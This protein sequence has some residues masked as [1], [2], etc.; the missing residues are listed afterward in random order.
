MNKLRTAVGFCKSKKWLMTRLPSKWTATYEYNSRM[1]AFTVS[2]CLGT[3]SEGLA[4]RTTTGQYSLR[5]IA[6]FR[7]YHSRTRRQ[8]VDGSTRAWVGFS[9]CGPALSPTPLSRNVDRGWGV[10]KSCHSL[11][12][13]HYTTSCRDDARRRN[14]SITCCKG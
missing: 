8:I 3:R 9:D 5:T 13:P 1:T 11:L 6:S 10:S 14:S 12:E 4:T 7:P 2:H